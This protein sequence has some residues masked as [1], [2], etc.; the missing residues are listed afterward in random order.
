MF[1]INNI[2]KDKLRV[3]K[4]DLKLTNIFIVKFIFIVY[5]IRQTF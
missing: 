4:I 3:K 5:K 2:I 1:L